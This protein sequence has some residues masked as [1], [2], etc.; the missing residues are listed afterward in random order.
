VQDLLRILEKTGVGFE[1]CREEI[2][3]PRREEQA[4]LRKAD[5]R[6]LLYT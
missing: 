5:C 4:E 2:S 3:H 6:L 1:G